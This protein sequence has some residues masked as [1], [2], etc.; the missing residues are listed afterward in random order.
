MK[1]QVCVKVS[2]EHL[3]VLVQNGDHSSMSALYN[4]YFK[5]VYQKCFSFVKNDDDAY[6]LT[7]DIMIKVFDKISFYKGKSSFSTWLYAIAH[8]HCITYIVKQNK[9]RKESIY[10]VPDL[11]DDSVSDNYELRDESEKREIYLLNILNEMPVVEREMLEKKYRYNYSILDLQKE[12]NL[13]ASAVKMRLMRARQKM[14]QKFPVV[15]A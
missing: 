10:S 8:N 14:E 2:D 12:F 15:A 9:Q 3:V 6:D 4:K 11:A 7:Q 13:S 1:S 5:L